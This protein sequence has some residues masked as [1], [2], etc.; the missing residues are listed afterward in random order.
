MKQTQLTTRLERLSQ[1]KG[2]GLVN[3]YTSLG[4]NGYWSGGYFVPK[5]TFCA[6]PKEKEAAAKIFTEQ[7]NPKASNEI[8]AHCSMFKPEKNERYEEMLEKST[9]YVLEWVKNDPR[10]V[11]DE[12]KP[13]R[14]LLTRSKSE[15]QL[16][17]D[18]GKIL[19]Q[20]EESGEGQK[21]GEQEDEDQL[22]AILKSQDMPQPEDGG[23]NDEELKNATEVPLP[24]DEEV[25]KDGSL[26][27]AAEVP[28]PA[29]EGKEEI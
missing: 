5:R 29:E 19:G 8:E 6:I 3:I 18:D 23:V 28:L 15:S 14:E 26:E 25:F 27:K 21:D 9:E 11:V 4:E 1:L 17:D 22:Q 20:E 10:R 13:S 7:P 16:W 2:V 12:Y 24:A